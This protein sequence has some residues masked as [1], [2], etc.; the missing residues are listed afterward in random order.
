MSKQMKEEN[1]EP[2]RFSILNPQQNCRLVLT[3]DTYSETET[4]V[5]ARIAHWTKQGIKDTFYMY[6]PIC[7]SF[8][9]QEGSPLC[10]LSARD[11]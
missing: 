11:T 4:L 3:R 6:V 1:L 10:N 8:N 9:S 2:F 7:L 5:P